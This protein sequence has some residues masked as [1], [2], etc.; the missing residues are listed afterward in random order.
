MKNVAWIVEGKPQYDIYFVDELIQKVKTQYFY[1]GTTNW[2]Y[3]D[4]LFVDYSLKI[5]K[6]YP[7]IVQVLPNL[8]EDKSM[9]IN[10]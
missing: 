6:Q 1:F 4:S 10:A 2:K 8:N 7:E 9:A 3:S 5:L